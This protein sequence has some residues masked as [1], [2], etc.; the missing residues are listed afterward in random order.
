MSVLRLCKAPVAQVRC[1][2][3]LLAATLPGAAGLAVQG[4]ANP[5]SQVKSTPAGGAGI[6]VDQAAH[7][8]KFL[9]AS[10]PNLKQVGYVQLPDNVWRPL[11]LGKVTS[12]KGVAVDVPN[13]RLYV[14]DPPEGKIWWYELF[15]RANGMLGSTGEQ[16]VAVE[17]YSVYWMAVNGVGDLY[18]TGKQIVTPPQ[19]SYDAVFRQ[20]AINIATKNP[21]RVKEIYTRSNSGN[22]NPKV[23]MPSGI[24]VDSFYIYWGNQELGQTHGSVSKGPRQNI[25]KV[26]D[27]TIRPLSTAVEEVRGIASTGTNLFYVTPQGVYGVQKSQATPIASA[28]EGLVAEPPVTDTNSLGFDPRSV[29]WD[30]DGTMYFTE[31]TSGTVYSLPA[32]N[33]AIHNLTK[34]VDAPGVYGVT[35]MNFDLL[36]NGA[37]HGH[38]GLHVLVVAVAA[39]F[40]ARW[41]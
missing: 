35:V 3:C 15:V 30:G 11:V 10:F 14:A 27:T 33:L 39:A 8:R 18:F 40:L 16:H 13:R 34:F 7:S 12:P 36:P 20:D 4:P 22:P 41:Q 26:S 23:W 17:G 29:A 24:A 21:T 1:F 37:Y 25:G 5:Y 38:G 6:T 32:E 28:T 2:L 31:Y 19:S 9:I